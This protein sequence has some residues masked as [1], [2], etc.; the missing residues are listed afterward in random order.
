MYCFALCTDGEFI[1]CLIDL[2]IDL[3][4][5]MQGFPTLAWGDASS[6]E[7]YNGGRDYESMKEFADEF[8]TKP[9]CSI[10][11]LDACTKEEKADIA[12]V[13]AKTD[14]ELSAIAEKIAK[15]AKDANKEFEEYLDRLNEEY[16]L[17][18]KK[19]N[20]KVD[21][22]KADNKFKYIQQV[23]TKRGISNSLKD[24]DED[25]DDMMG[26]EF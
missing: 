6:A 14:D 1:H 25:D 23:L 10:F 13:E 4:T 5:T 16:E 20:D 8:V 12:V 3:R 7:D 17:Q 9:S 24:I 21:A 26:D 18:Q 11:N 22:I 19:F 2:L 15:E